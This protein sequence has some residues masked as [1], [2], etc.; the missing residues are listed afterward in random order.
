M[1]RDGGG[2][3]D[4]FARS[5]EFCVV[6]LRFQSIL[7]RVLSVARSLFS[8]RKG[9][10]MNERIGFGLRL[11]ASLI[12]GIVIGFIGSLVGGVAG[13]ILGG[14]AGALAGSAVDQTA[15]GGAFGGL[16]GAVVGAMLGSSLVSLIWVIWEGLTGQALGKLLLK[17]RVK[18]ADGSNAGV[19]RLL[20]RAAIKYI[21]SIL[22]I[23]AAVTGISLIGNLGSLA[24]VVIFV[25]CF[26]VLGQ[27]RQALHDILA[28]TAVY[29]S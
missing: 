27:N 6:A 10:I 5:G 26:L 22:Q 18:S 2:M 1:P 13:G 20:T 8:F 12:D 4:A 21:S 7:Y 24:G 29:K 14:G 25:G 9:P 3:V 15:A 23:V 17:I 16:V 19:D 11:V 28:K